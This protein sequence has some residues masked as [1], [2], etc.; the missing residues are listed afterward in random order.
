MLAVSF[1]MRLCTS[2]VSA[3]LVLVFLSVWCLVV[4]GDCSLGSS[5]CNGTSLL[6][7]RASEVSEGIAVTTGVA[8]QGMLTTFTEI[9]VENY[10]WKETS[11]SPEEYLDAYCDQI[12]DS[13]KI[14]DLLL[15]D[16]LSYLPVKTRTMRIPKCKLMGCFPCHCA[17]V[18]NSLSDRCCSESVSMLNPMYRVDC[19]VKKLVVIVSCPDSWVSDDVKKN[20]EE[21]VS[22]WTMT[23]LVTDV[24]TKRTFRNKDCAACHRAT[25]LVTWTREVSCK[26]FQYVYTAR[27]E[28]ELMRQASAGSHTT[29]NVLYNPLEDANLLKCTTTASYLSNVISTCNTTGRWEA[30]DRNIKDG[31]LKLS[32][33]YRVTI[34]DSR[35]R[36]NVFC[37]VCNGDQPRV[38]N[39][40]QIVEKSPGLPPLSLLFGLSSDTMRDTTLST[41]GCA[42]GRETDFNVSHVTL[43]LSH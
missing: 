23:R 2:R 6:T 11:Q 41:S 7:N 17:G 10:T 34:P 24:K 25:S 35:L 28:V 21:G 40:D 39:C 12:Y 22:D 38:T 4:N 18:C 13:P 33:I 30:Y 1:T 26:V 15:W 42:S 29:C 5:S 43:L 16:G 9:S 3:L 8:R 31:C 19:V 20:C 37:V 32:D 36:Q 27:S 14:T